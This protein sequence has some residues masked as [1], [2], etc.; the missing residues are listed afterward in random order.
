[1]AKRFRG[2]RGRGKKRFFS[3]K[4]KSLD[5]LLKEQQKYFLWKPTSPQDQVI[6]GRKYRHQRISYGIIYIHKLS[7]IELKIFM[8]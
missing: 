4:T 1:M 6:S 8:Y 5:F 3:F 7:S 2:G